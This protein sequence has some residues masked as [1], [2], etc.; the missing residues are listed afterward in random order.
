MDELISNEKGT[1][2]K[3][4]MKVLITMKERERNEEVTKN[5]GRKQEIL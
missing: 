3:R 1:C 5:N 2:E 4:E